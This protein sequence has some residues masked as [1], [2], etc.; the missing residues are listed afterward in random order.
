M[1]GGDESMKDRKVFRRT[2]CYGRTHMRQ[3]IGKIHRFF[4]DLA[5]GE[6]FLDECYYYNHIVANQLQI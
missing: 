2:I 1:T 4:S 3:T 6:T 5:L